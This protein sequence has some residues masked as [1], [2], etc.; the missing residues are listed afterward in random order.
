MSKNWLIK[1][2]TFDEVNWTTFANLK[3]IE[4]NDSLDMSLCWSKILPSIYSVK[5]LVINPTIA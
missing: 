1:T 5:V 4:L 3:A 2:I